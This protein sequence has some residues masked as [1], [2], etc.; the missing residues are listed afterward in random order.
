M[1]EKICETYDALT[2]Y[3]P[4]FL[5][6]LCV[7]LLCII[8]VGIGFGLAFLI[9]WIV[10]MIYNQ[11]ALLFNWPTFSIWFWFGVVV[12]VGWLR[13]GKFPISLNFKKEEK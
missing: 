2:Y 12:I 8:G 1:W 5:A 9:P 10:M 11:I 6:V 7:V 13:T 4:S 3:M